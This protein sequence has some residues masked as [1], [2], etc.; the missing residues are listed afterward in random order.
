MLSSTHAG[1]PPPPDGAS[2]HLKLGAMMSDIRSLTRIEL[3]STVD[4][5]TSESDVV[6]MGIALAYQSNRSTHT[7]PR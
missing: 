3:T 5:Q 2:T 1:P 6:V 4:E 7:E